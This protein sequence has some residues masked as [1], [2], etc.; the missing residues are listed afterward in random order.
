MFCLPVKI[1]GSPSKSVTETLINFFEPLSFRKDT[2]RADLI[3]STIANV[4]WPQIV[5]KF[6]E[7]RVTWTQN[8]ENGES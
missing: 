1:S 6:Y 2:D 3:P 4:K 5:I 8:N 7:E